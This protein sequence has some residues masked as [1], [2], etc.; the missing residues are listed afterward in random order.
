[1]LDNFVSFRRTQIMQELK[2]RQKEQEPNGKVYT[3]EEAQAWNAH[4]TEQ[5]RLATQE[6]DLVELGNVI[7]KSNEAVYQKLQKLIDS[8][9]KENNQV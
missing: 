7:Q 2:D 5:V 3:L 6:E 1:M 4:Y 9:S 8:I